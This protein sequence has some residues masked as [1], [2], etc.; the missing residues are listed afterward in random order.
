MW[1]GVCLYR[2]TPM[3]GRTIC[4]FVHPGWRSCNVYIMYYILRHLLTRSLPLYAP[5]KFLSMCLFS[6]KSVRRAPL[7]AVT[8]AVKSTFNS[9][10]FLTMYC[11]GPFRFQCLL[12]N[13]RLRGDWFVALSLLSSGVPTLLEFKSRRLDLA[14]YCSMHALRGFI[15]LLSRRAWFARPSHVFRLVVFLLSFGYIFHQ[16]DHAP[17]S[18]HANLRKSLNWVVGL[19]SRA[20]AATAEVT[21]PPTPSLPL[22]EAT[23]QVSAVELGVS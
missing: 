1:S 12:G 18:L 9:A 4:Q 19:E 13:S 2:R 20:P 3:D 14:L 22:A 10:L 11:A 16:Y 15:L 8:K 23:F 21:L 5:L 6:W 17:D 7:A